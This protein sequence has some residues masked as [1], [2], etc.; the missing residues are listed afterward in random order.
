MQESYC[1]ASWVEKNGKVRHVKIINRL[2]AVIIGRNQ[3]K[4]RVTAAAL[5]IQIPIW[6]HYCIV[7][8]LMCNDSASLPYVKVPILRKMKGCVQ[9]RRMLHCFTVNQLNR[10]HL[11]NNRSDHI[12]KHSLTTYFRSQIAL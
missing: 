6:K 11:S 8:G 12:K 7:K 1:N 2:Y 5:S 3:R 4:T 9:N 10:H